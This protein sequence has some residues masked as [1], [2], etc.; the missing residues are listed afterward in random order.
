MRMKVPSA[1]I[2]LVAA[3]AAASA[4]A[5]ACGDEEESLPIATNPVVTPT[6]TPVDESGVA[7]ED[8][9]TIPPEPSY[10][11][12]TR[13]TIAGIE[14][15]LPEWM[16]YGEARMLG[17]EE[18]WHQFTYFRDGD[19]LSSYLLIDR[20]GVIVGG[21][22]RSAHVDAFEAI[23]A[24]AK[25]PKPPTESPGSITIGGV[26]VALPPGA[27]FGAETG[28]A[29]RVWSITYDPD[30]L[31]TG[32]NASDYGISTLRIREDGVI[33]KDELLPEHRPTFATVLNAA[34]A[35]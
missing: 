10:T 25:A 34:V 20:D 26:L 11:A 9:P 14:I 3:L 24:T 30:P 23:L 19:A 13:V 12:I 28:Y 27:T 2:T 7:I 18:T 1:R 35:E 17:G 16:T 6:A 21:T 32:D 5:F 22:I 8:R 4:L 31:N 29:P 33:L 15:E